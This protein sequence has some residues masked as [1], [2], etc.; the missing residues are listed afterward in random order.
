M[1]GAVRYRKIA[2]IGS[3][4]FSTVWQ[5]EDL[6]GKGGGGAGGGTLNLVAVKEVDRITATMSDVSIASLWTERRVLK[7]LSAL[8][9]SG[10]NGGELQAQEEYHEE[11]LQHR[12]RQDSD[13]LN[14]NENDEEVFLN[15]DAKEMTS[16][17]YQ[18]KNAS[19]TR[20]TSPTLL[21]D[22]HYSSGPS[23]SLAGS[24]SSRPFVQLLETF[25]TPTSV[26]FVLE[27]VDGGTLWDHIR[28]C[29]QKR[30]ELGEENPHW[31]RSHA[32]TELQRGIG[33]NTTVTGREQGINV[34]AC[35]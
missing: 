1:A 12:P 6:Q 13:M 29:M 15:E 23:P 7:K 19:P 4:G 9:V 33:K 31:C 28:H 26:N 21:Q 20:N 2:P 35:S 11:E 5:C 30:R 18:K 32:D 14:L 24:D 25:A 22:Q 8:A 27:V 17:L 16:Y 3:G 10:G 34:W